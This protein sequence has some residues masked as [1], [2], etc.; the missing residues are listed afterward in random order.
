MICLKA[1]R[2]LSHLLQ[3]DQEVITEAANAVLLREPDP[4]V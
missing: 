4:G 3:R 2:C 1:G